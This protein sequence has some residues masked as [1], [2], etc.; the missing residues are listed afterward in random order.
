MRPNGVR[1]REPKSQDI[2]LRLLVKVGGPEAALHEPHEPAPPLLVP[3]GEYR[4]GG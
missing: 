1:R 3:H 2:Y 4:G